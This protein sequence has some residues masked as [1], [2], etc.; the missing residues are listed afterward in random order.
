LNHWETMKSD[1]KIGNEM[2]RYNR[3]VMDKHT[4][5]ARMGRVL[6]EMLG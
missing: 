3:S 2:L 1:P 4:Y 6:L 5:E